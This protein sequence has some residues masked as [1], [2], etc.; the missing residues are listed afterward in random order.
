MTVVALLS[1]ALRHGDLFDSGDADLVFAFV[2]GS[3][4]LAIASVLI[5]IRA[6]HWMLRFAGVLAVALGLGAVFYTTDEYMFM[7]AFA[8]A[9][10]LIQGL[11]LSAWL[12][13]GQILP[14]KKT[15]VVGES[16]PQLTP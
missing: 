4:V 15:P 8:M 1:F 6:G 14:I 13:S 5:W 7:M 2:G 3:V 9:H 16:Q 12:T 10:Y 11:V